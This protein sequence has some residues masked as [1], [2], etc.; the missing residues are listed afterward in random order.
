MEVGPDYL[1]GFLRSGGNPA[2][3]LFHV[4]LPR[5]ILIIEGKD[6]VCRVLGLRIVE[7]ESW[8][9]FVSQLNFTARKINRAPI[10]PAW[11]ACFKPAYLKTELREVLAQGRVSVS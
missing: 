3:H 5:F 9:G 10:E 11:R 4:E 6:I 8:R 7:C 1:M 2:W